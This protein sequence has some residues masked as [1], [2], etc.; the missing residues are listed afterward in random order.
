[1]NAPNIEFFFIIFF[2]IFFFYPS[3]IP[4]KKFK[5]SFPIL[6]KSHRKSMELLIN[7]ILLR[8]AIHLSIMNAP[9][10]YQAGKI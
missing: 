5:F 7:V 4:Q 1:M 3:E 9:I 2:L 10:Q 6:K 8:Y